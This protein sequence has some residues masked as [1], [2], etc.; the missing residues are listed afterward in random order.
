MW[1]GLC[2]AACG[3]GLG[4]RTKAASKLPSPNLEAEEESKSRKSPCTPMRN[5]AGT[6]GSAL[7]SA[8]LS[9]SAATFC[10]HAGVAT[11]SLVAPG[12]MPPPEGISSPQSLKLRATHVRTAVSAPLTSTPARQ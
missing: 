12:A 5:G 1:R 10:H 11:R 2:G 9:C 4:R 3:L 6:K 7:P 8:L